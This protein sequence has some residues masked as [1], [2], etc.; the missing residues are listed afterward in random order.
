MTAPKDTK[1][2]KEKERKEEGKKEEEEEGEEVSVTSVLVMWPFSNWSVDTVG[3][4]GR[5]TFQPKL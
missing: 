1:E 4:D 5:Y 2:M 3:F